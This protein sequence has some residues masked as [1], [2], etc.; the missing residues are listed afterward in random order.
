MTDP[1]L[2]VGAGPTG[3]TAAMELSRQGVPV[4]LIDK[5]DHPDTTSRAIGVQARTL[6]LFEQRGLADELVRLGNKG[7]FGSVYGGGERVFRLDFAHTESRYPY[8]LFVSQAETER[9]LREFL[10]KQGVVP[11][12]RTELVAIQQNAHEAGVTPAHAVLRRADGTLEYIAASWIIA[13]DGA[14][15]V[16]R[17]TLSL[18]YDGH[19]REEHYALGDMMIDGALADT[20]LHIFSSDHGFMGVFPMGGAHFRLIA[21]YPPDQTAAHPA[22]GSPG[23]PNAAP[24][25]AALQRLYDQRSPIPATMRDMTWSSWFRINSRMVSTLK[26]GAVFLG[27]DAAHIHSPAGAQGMNTGIQD[28]INLCWKLAWVVK[29][30]ASVDLLRTYEADRLPVMRGVLSRTDKL[31]TLIGTENQAV[32]TL[33]N[34]VGPWIGG[35]GTVQENATAGMSQ[36]A[37]HYRDSPLSEQYGHFGKLHAGD[38]LPEVAVRYRDHGVRESIR[39]LSLLDA[40]EFTLL[41]VAGDKIS[42]GP[43]D[44]DGWQTVIRGMHVVHIMPAVD[45]TSR[46]KFW[47]QFG[48]VDSATLVRPDGYAALRCRLVDAKQYIAAYATKWLS[49]VASEPPAT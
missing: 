23:P 14:H 22:A 20:D 10:A 18:A 43:D 48:D 39:L 9:V 15:S 46:E 44:L 7:L 3:L 31:T 13:A 28:M 2:I 8:I 30:K 37:L 16:L 24:S 49:A 6:E 38:R 45:P 42:N 1:I 36:L 11:Q 12:W 34:H 29:G 25:L 35:N 5:R 27:G 4:R 17:S 19:A 26:V 47:E 40:A 33:F 41:L 32:R 21:S